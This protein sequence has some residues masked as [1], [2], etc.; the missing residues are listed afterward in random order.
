MIHRNTSRSAFTLIELL[1]VIAI[2]AIL[3]AILF[4]VFAQAKEAAKKTSCL[5]NT[6]Q[7]GLA[8]I[9]YAN[10]Y[11]DTMAT[12]V[13]SDA[14]APAG[15][16]FGG[17]TPLYEYWFDASYN[18]FT[19]TK[20]SQLYP[21]TK[22][23]QI[24]SC[25]S[26]AGL[27][28]NG[29]PIDYGFNANILSGYDYYTGAAYPGPNTSSPNY[30]MITT[31]AETI[32]IGDSESVKD[33]F[34]AMAVGGDLEFGFATQGG[35]HGLHSNQANIGWLDGHSKSMQVS[36]DLNYDAALEQHWS[37]PTGIVSAWHAGDILKHPL[38]PTPNEAAWDPSSGGWSRT[39]AAAAA[40]YYYQ[41]VKTTSG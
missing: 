31:T 36:Q 1:V 30:S 8:Y 35:A 33:D 7:I 21:Y 41:M 25:P 2:I 20:G 19:S 22:N 11:D 23:I 3:A 32:L 37:L 15:S 18:Y 16:P 5:S 29:L 6:K 24:G 17:T 13:Y 26:A 9:M 10:D 28:N 12:G 27:E 39:P 40:G 4:P 38:P 34:T 14:D